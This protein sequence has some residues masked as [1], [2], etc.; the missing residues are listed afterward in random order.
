[1]QLQSELLDIG[2]GR[3]APPEPPWERD[4]GSRCYVRAQHELS[5]ERA[6]RRAPVAKY[7]PGRAA[8]CASGIP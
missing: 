5:A 8:P 7:E 1:M 4:A 6:P 2:S 3:L